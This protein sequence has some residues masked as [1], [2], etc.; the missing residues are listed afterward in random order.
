VFLEPSLIRQGEPCAA[1]RR[2]LRDRPR[3]RSL[4]GD[5]YDEA[6]LAGEVGHEG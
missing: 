4:V 6:E 1:T 5:A 3:Q 2:G